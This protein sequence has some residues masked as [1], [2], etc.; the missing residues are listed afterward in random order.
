MTSNVR[1]AERTAISTI[2]AMTPSKI[3]YGRMPDAANS[4]E[5]D[6]D[7][8]Y[9]AVPLMCRL[10]AGSSRRAL[11]IY[12]NRRLPHFRD[13]VTFNEKVN[14]RIL[15]D[16]RPLLEWTCDKLAMKEGARTIP[17]LRMPRTLWV[18]SSVR[19]LED[20]ELPEHWVLKPN[21]RTGIVYFGHGRPDI[22]SLATI[23]STWLRSAEFED[24][25]EWAYSKAR[26]ILLAEELL[27]VPG[28]PPPDY[29]FF[30]FAGQVAAVQVDVGRHSVHQRRIY[31]PDWAPLEIS[32]GNYPL[33]PIE[34]PPENLEGM[35]AIAREIGRPFDFI[36]VDLYSIDGVTVFGEVTPYAGS[37]LDRFVPGSFDAELG[38]RW[39]LPY[40]GPEDR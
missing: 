37:G 4:V 13:P 15:N 31:L 23:T 39:E 7:I 6:V 8:R 33:A 21:H 14:W 24:L 25:H 16:R 1:Q 40:V 38:A 18:G 30:V 26:P 3:R 29:K 27:G 11:F 17:G 28:S 34:P 32:S 19:E 12:F 5:T 20:A 35:L 10:P 9:A 22:T 36:R 2:I